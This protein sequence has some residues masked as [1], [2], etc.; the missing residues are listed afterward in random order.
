MMTKKKR[1]RKKGGRMKTNGLFSLSS[2]GEECKN[3]EFN[4]YEKL[5]L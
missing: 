4:A 3:G 5:F 2:S 1:K